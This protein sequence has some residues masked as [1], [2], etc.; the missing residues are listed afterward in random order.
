MNNEFTQPRSIVNT[1]GNKQ[2]I[3]RDFGIKPNEIM[4]LDSKVLIDSYPVLY[5]RTSQTTWLTGSAVGTPVSWT[6]A[7]D[8]MNLITNQGIYN[9]KRIYD[10]HSN[11][12]DKLYDPLGLGLVFKQ[13]A[14]NNFWPDVHPDAKVHRMND[15]MFLGAATKNDGK[16]TSAI[17]SDNKDWLEQ[18][19]G[20]TMNNTQ[21]G[22]ISTIGQCAIL[23]ASR[24]SDFGAEGSMGCIGLQG[25]AIND[26]TTHLQT[27]YGAYLEVRRNVGAG[28]THGFEL[29]VV[30]YG[31]A[32]SIQPY[33]MFQQGL[34]VGGWIASGGEIATTRAS[35]ALAIINNGSTWE[36]G[37][38]FHSIALEGSNG[39]TGAGVAIEMAKGH[40]VRWMFGSGSQGASVASSVSNSA[41]EQSLQFSDLGTLI[42]NSESKSM[43]Q[44]EVSNTFVNGIL[45]SPSNPG[46][47]VS[48]SA[49]GDDANID[50]RITPK[51]T[52]RFHLSGVTVTGTAGAQSGFMIWKLNNTEVKIPYFNMQ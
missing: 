23:G 3:A 32:V 5:D 24:T 47:G 39:I 14:S 41:A 34:T 6:I 33:D 19:R 51:G 7:G 52:G 9:L 31:S 15:R 27:A 43:L 37:I 42:R 48:L 8:T 13:P 12:V 4:Y 18:I 25:W 30:N 35:A 49:Q 21:L 44:V 50:F 10:I 38:V 29:D 26:N 20:S 36:K 22:V 28:R 11:N 17:N 16:I 46:F 1:E 40:V 2:S 45:V